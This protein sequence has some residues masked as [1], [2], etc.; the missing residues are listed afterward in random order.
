MERRGKEG[1]MQVVVSMAKETVEKKE[2]E[3][4]NGLKRK[5]GW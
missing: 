5:G 1:G 4:Q 3:G 2:K